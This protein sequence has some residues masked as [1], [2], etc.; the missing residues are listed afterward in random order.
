M[1]LSVKQMHRA[2]RIGKPRKLRF[3][4]CRLNAGVRQQ[5][6]YPLALRPTMRCLQ[7]P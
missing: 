6:F 1:Q 7:R 3:C 4:V 5:F 2:F